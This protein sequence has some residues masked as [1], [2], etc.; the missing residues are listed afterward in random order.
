DGEAAGFEHAPFDLRGP[1][2]QVHVAAVHLRPGVEDGDD[3]LAQV[4]LGFDAELLHP[5][6][7]TE[8]PLAR[9]PVAAEPVVAAQFLRGPGHER[10]P[11]R[12]QDRRISVTASR[13]SLG[14]TRRG[15][16]TSRP[17]RPSWASAS[18]TTLTLSADP[19]AARR[20][21]NGRISSQVS[22]A[23]AP[24]PVRSAPSRDSDSD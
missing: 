16:P 1:F 10:A 6:P 8:H 11:S 20:S 7:V 24:S 14:S 13:V 23:P 3:R 2:A 21:S 19:P 4:F 5:R 9:R 12:S 18:L 15:G 17:H 22:I